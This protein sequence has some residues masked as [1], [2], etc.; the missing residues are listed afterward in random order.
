M[1]IPARHIILILGLMLMLAGCAFYP[2]VQVAGGAMTG[3]DAAILADDYLPRDSIEG[4]ALNCNT[5][6]M[7]ERRMRER[8][9]MDNLPM[10]SAHVINGN[11]YLVGQFAQRADADRAIAIASSVQG[12]KLINCKFYPMA[13][14]REM[15]SDT[16]LL[17]KVTK[18]LAA[19]K[20]LDNADLRIEVI[21]AN[22]IL[23]GCAGNYNQKTAALAIAS[24]VGGIREVVDYIVVRPMP[25][26]ATRKVAYKK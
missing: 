2:V 7:M 15:R 3:Y 26:N 20:R 11:A 12:I 5:D 25:E 19:T 24:E 13:T 8:L 16:K 14:P 6:K 21:R 1:K 4:G 17:A 9:A 22:A 10:V 23:V 18:R